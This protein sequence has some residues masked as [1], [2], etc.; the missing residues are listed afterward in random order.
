MVGDI[1]G[2]EDEVA[3]RLPGFRQLE[4]DLR[5]FDDAKLAALERDDADCFGG[6]RLLDD[7]GAAVRT[8]SDAV[9]EEDGVGD[10]NEAVVDAVGVEVGDVTGGEVGKD[11]CGGRGGERR[12]KGG[13]DSAVAIRRDGDRGGGVEENLALVGEAREN[14][15]FTS[16]AAAKALGARPTYPAQ[17]RRRLPPLAQKTS[18]SQKTPPS[19]ASSVH[20]S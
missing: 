7:F 12:A 6:F 15:W 11:G 16:S 18:S 10:A 13:I 14:A 2:A 5:V 20:W 4:R 3:I 9:A 19:A 8:C 1:G 17:R